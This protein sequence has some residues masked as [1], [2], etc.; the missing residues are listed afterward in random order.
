MAKTWLLNGNI[1]TPMGIIH[2][3]LAIE[4]G[5]C[6][7]IVSEEMFVAFQLGPEDT[8]YDV[9]GCDV[10]PSLVDLHHDA[11]EKAWNPRVGVHVPLTL[12]LE[13]VDKQAAMNGFG[14]IFHA[15]T[16]SGQT[17]V[18]SL[19]AV[20]ELLD[21]LSKWRDSGKG[22]V[23]H[24]VHLRWEIPYEEATPMVMKWLTEGG[25]DLLSVMD[26]SPGQG[27]MLSKDRHD[28]Y[29][30]K[31]GGETISSVATAEFAQKT[32]SEQSLRAIL[33]AARIM[34]IPVAAHDVVTPSEVEHWNAQG[35]VGCEFP[36]QLDTARVAKAKDMA[37][38]VGA[39]NVLRG[40]SHEKWLSAREAILAGAVDVL[41]SDY[42]PPATLPAIYTLVDL[43]LPLQEAVDLCTTGPMKM[44]ESGTYRSSLRYGEA[45]DIVVVHKQAG[46]W[47]V[48]KQL[49][50]NG[51]LVMSRL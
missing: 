37:V 16:C 8:R 14:T 7:D 24:F 3:H 1:V 25:I 22:L 5:K 50:H 15:V 51:D 13:T 23:N 18:R 48:V 26:H 47:P 49:W 36:L 11:Y 28:Y 4:S 20:T 19:S 12:A 31:L 43:G 32:R 39:P 38:I 30:A 21:E 2:G 40:E 34:G 33:Q 35:V 41:V 44:I 17:P 9:S 10:F 29:L 46:D 45:A 6:S 27:K 42:Y